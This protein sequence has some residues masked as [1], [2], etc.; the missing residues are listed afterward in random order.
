M[1]NFDFPPLK[2]RNRFREERYQEEEEEKQ[3][4]QG[5]DER[6]R[7]LKKDIKNFNYIKTTMAEINK[8]AV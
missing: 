4:Q 1:N 3:Y 7:Y 8:I 5:R 6:T 2:N